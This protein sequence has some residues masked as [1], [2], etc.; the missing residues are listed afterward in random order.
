MVSN[1]SHEPVC[2]VA[3]RLMYDINYVYVRCLIWINIETCVQ[4]RHW[5]RLV[6]SSGGIVEVAVISSTTTFHLSSYF[7]TKSQIKGSRKGEEKDSKNS[8]KLNHVTNQN[9]EQNLNVCSS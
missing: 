5:C 3:E 7:T 4:S 6:L 8:A 1:Y 2:V 9:L